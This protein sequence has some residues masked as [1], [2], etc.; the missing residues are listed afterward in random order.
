MALLDSYSEI[1]MCVGLGLCIGASLIVAT[2]TIR[3][4]RSLFDRLRLIRTGTQALLNIG[5]RKTIGNLYQ[6]WFPTKTTILLHTSGK[7]VKIGYHRC[8]LDY[9]IV[10]P[11]RRELVSK[12]AGSQVW[13]SKD[14]VL[15]DIT[16]QPGIPYLISA[17]M[18][19]ADYIVVKKGG[20]ETRFT[21]DQIPNFG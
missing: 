5:M 4:P 10:A 6:I 11:Y 13:C 3:K 14:D 8:G 1:G 2:L 17:N 20:L 15:I 21:G 16:Q 19:D 7:S 12:M 9:N 18:L